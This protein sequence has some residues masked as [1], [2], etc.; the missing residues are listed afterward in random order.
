MRYDCQLALPPGW[1]AGPDGLHRLRCADGTALVIKRRRDAAP[2]FFAA[3]ARGLSAL[4]AAAGLRTPAVYACSERAIAIEDLGHGR[5]SGAD[6]RD[7][8]VALARQHAVRGP[9]FGFDAPGFIGDSPQDN[10][11]LTDG[12]RFFAERRLLP[13]A[14]R[15][16]DADLLGRAQAQQV[17]VL[18]GRLAQWLP[19]A[20]PVL[21]HGDLWRGNLHA[22]A[23]GELALIDAG[24]AHFG[25]A[26]CDLAMLE[27][28]GAP[29][30]G[31]FAAYEA[32]PN[33][34]GW[35]EHAAL[36]NLYHLLNHLNL[37]GAGYLPA[38]RAVIARYA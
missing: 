24:A 33:L 27:L 25:W 22:C 31:F 34:R 5:A 28:F 11:W 23:S 18:C 20:E 13:Q 35:R 19:Q 37:F 32:A 36:L 15:A 6:W 9:A 2:G 7:A 17:E 4:A 3:E 26:A 8:G 30:P 12:H 14:R 29:P 16:R 21:L 10:R 38:V 1:E